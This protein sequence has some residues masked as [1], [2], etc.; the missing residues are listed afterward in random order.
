MTNLNILKIDSSARSKDSTSRL[1]NKHVLEHVSSQNAEVSV[2][3][4][5]LAQ[6]LPPV[7]EG[8]VQA[9]FTPVADRNAE[10][11]D[12][13]KLSDTLI[14]EI[15][16]ADVIILSLPMYN[17]GIPSTLK[18][19]IDLIARSGVTFKYTETGP[20]GLLENKRVILSVASG[21]V[22][23]GTPFDYATPYLSHVLN[24]I[25]ITEISII[26]TSGLNSNDELSQ[27][28]ALQKIADLNVKA[29]T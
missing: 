19:W 7:T 15:Q 9:A 14:A 2:V 20:V 12:I 11:N 5:D 4:R 24:F 23:V 3:E 21:G 6:N 28:D 1:L 10:Q 17:F 25:G 29:A 22:P 27:S 16:A 8:W 13:L 26:S 18:A